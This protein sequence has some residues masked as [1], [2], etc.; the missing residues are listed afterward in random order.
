ME[1]VKV[2]EEMGAEVVGVASIVNRT[3]KDLDFPL[4]IYSA[5]R[6]DIVSYDSEECPL[7]KEGKIELVKPGSRD[8]KKTK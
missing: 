1:T 5:I 4:P 7:C 6:L 3:G 8:F 2:L